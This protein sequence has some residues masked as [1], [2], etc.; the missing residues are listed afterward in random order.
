MAD[1]IIVM[2]DGMLKEEGA[3]NELT[4]LKGHYAEMFNVQAER[5]Q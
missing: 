4:A 5:Y 1:H 3:H 2:E